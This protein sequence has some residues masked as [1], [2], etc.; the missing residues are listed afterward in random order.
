MVNGST[1]GLRF[2]DLRRHAIT[3]LAESQASDRTIMSIAGALANQGSLSIKFQ[4]RNSVRPMHL[5]GP[6]PR[7]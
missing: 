2:H 6:Q 4:V 5:F 1:A 7:S 3:E